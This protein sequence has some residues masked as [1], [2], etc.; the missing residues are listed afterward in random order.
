MSEP[1]G[2]GSVRSDLTRITLA[3]GR[4]P[5]EVGD[6]DGPPWRLRGA[7]RLLEAPNADLV[8]VLG[9]ASACPLSADLM[10]APTRT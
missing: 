5:T 9:D 4:S 1:S 3:A 10:A 8:E 7:V 6:L 2:M